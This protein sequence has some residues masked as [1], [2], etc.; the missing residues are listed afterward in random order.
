MKRKKTI[1]LKGIVCILAVMLAAGSLL[2]AVT[3]KMASQNNENE[4]NLDLGSIDTSKFRN[5]EE[6]DK[7]NGN[8][9][10][11]SETSTVYKNLPFGFYFE[12]PNTFEAK[13]SDSQTLY[14]IY[15]DTQI[16]F[17]Y[18]TDDYISNEIFR[19]S[20]KTYL[21]SSFYQPNLKSTY[22]VLEY[23]R[24][25]CYPVTD[26]A[27]SGIEAIKEY[28]YMNYISSSYDKTILPNTCAYYATLNNKGYLLYAVSQT[29]D[30][31][32]LD[33]ILYNILNSMK[34]Y[35]PVSQEL[36]VSDSFSSY[37]DKDSG[38]HFDYPSSWNQTDNSN[39]LVSFIPVNSSSN[40]Y[41]NFR[42]DFISDKDKHYVTDA[43]QFS[44]GASKEL[45]LSYM[46]NEIPADA[47][48][49]NTAIHYCNLI[50]IKGKSAVNYEIVETLR[51]HTLA[52]SSFLP[53]TGNHLFCIRYTVSVNG[54]PTMINFTYPE[55]QK[56]LVQSLVDKIIKSYSWY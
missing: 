56:E 31:E 8:I 40:A 50:D 47:L 22:S 43:A 41:S 27:D 24:S 32:S 30:S 46:T 19:N 48:T 4:N 17:R 35:T 45:G 7:S 54:V 49:V 3:K 5:L 14:L 25:D 29:Y 11:S 6:V 53:L 21:E 34:P 36:V 51:P 15:Q 44:S 10:P 2:T 39:G 52:A 26:L 55:E 13:E 12:Y 33:N 18:F 20:T 28:P 42:I 1:T 9:T 38:V 16:I 23:N 37:S